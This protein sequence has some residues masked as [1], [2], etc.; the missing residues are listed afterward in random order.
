MPLHLPLLLPLPFAGGAAGAGGYTRLYSCW[1]ACWYVRLFSRSTAY[2][3]LAL[4]KSMRSCG[5]KLRSA[6]STFKKSSMTSD[7][8]FTCST[9]LMDKIA[10]SSGSDR[11]CSTVDNKAVMRTFKSSNN[12][13]LPASMPKCANNRLIQICVQPLKHK[14][15]QIF[16][17]Y[18]QPDLTRSAATTWSLAK[19]EYPSYAEPTHCCK[20]MT[21]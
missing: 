17:I 1:K 3:F 18:I 15:A 21:Q 8:A 7:S 4:V 11:G 16:N 13:R 5:R 2:A 20:L 6:P 9:I 12:E 10:R 14:R 19:L